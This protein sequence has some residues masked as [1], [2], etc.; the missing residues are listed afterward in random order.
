MLGRNEL[1]VGGQGSGISKTWG[2]RTLWLAVPFL[3][4]G[5]LPSA[6]GHRL[7]ADYRVLPNHRIQIESW[8][9]L[10]GESPRDAAVQVFRDNGELVTDGKLDDRGLFIFTCAE[11]GPLRI[12]VSAG[13]GHRKE[14]QITADELS[15]GANEPNAVARSEATDDPGPF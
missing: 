15:R 13:G 11:P 14:L 6:W 1:G 5:P 2:A 9:D 4:F 12:V 8:F 10:T 7:E 3:M